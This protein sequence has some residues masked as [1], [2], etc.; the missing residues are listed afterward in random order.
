MHAVKK[1]LESLTREKLAEMPE[2]DGT[3]HRC[4]FVGST[5]EGSLVCNECRARA[6][7][8]DFVGPHSPYIF[9]VDGE[10]S[11]SITCGYR[12]RRFGT[13]ID[14]RGFGELMLR[15]VYSLQNRICGD[16]F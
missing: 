13:L 1:E 2:W 14:S 12:P 3:R 11:R 5:S 10:K 15:G 16:L 7:G 6:E 9:A 4:G 8:K